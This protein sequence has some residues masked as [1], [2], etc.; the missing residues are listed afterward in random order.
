MVLTGDG[1]DE[2]FGGYDRYLRLLRLERLGGLRGPAA[3]LLGAAGALAPGRHGERLSRVGERLRLPID[4]RYLSGV[5]LMRPDIA[6]RLRPGAGGPRHL[7]LPALD[8]PGS[9]LGAGDEALDRAVAIDLQSYLPDDIL[10]KLD[11]MAMA[12]SLEGRSPFLHPELAQFALQLPAH[13]RVRDG[14]GKHLLRVVAGKWLP[15]RASSKP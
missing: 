15:P 13:Q 12:A 7:H 14:R 11:R 1:G 3:A 4:E 6:Q 8:D 5:A 2:L 9:H 10:V